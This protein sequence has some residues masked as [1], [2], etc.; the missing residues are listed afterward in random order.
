MSCRAGPH[1]S[2]FPNHQQTPR[3]APAGASP[4]A[5][6][7]ATARPRRRLIGAAASVPPKVGRVH[8][9][10]VLGRT[11][12]PCPP[13]WGT[14]P[15]S[16]SDGGGQRSKSSFGLEPHRVDE[17]RYD[18]LRE[19]A[20]AIYA[21]PA[22]APDRPIACT[23]RDS[24][25]P[26]LRRR[27]SANCESYHR[28]PTLLTARPARDPPLRSSL[29]SD[30]RSI[31]GQH[32]LRCALPYVPR[33]PLS[34]PPLPPSRAAAPSFTFTRFTFCGSG[35]QHRERRLAY[36]SFLPLLG[37]S[38]E[39]DR[40]NPPS[41]SYPAS[42]GRLSPVS[43]FSSS[44][45][46][47]ARRPR[48]SARSILLEHRRLGRLV[49]V[50]DLADQLLQHVFDRHQARPCRRTRPAR[51]RCEPSAAGSRAAGRAA[52]WS[53]ARK[54]AGRMAERMSNCS[55]GSPRCFSRSRA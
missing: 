38:P 4:R 7:S 19:I 6:S 22:A 8:I 1:R 39:R 3:S 52:A 17:N 23:Q 33:P 2:Q 24:A 51:W 35:V 13:P 48:T 32:P 46:R 45:C 16:S 18:H 31:P 9:A 53:R 12:C 54:K 21:Q 25:P 40:Y 28:P 26:S 14:S 50:A 49:L 41:V 44:T 47:S 15:R 27:D 34:L 5:R 30:A 29:R 55:G 37:M 42:S 11:L 10:L 43:R 36:S 20:S